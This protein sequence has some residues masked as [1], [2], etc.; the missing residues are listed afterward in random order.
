M[1]AFSGSIA[2]NSE[3]LRWGNRYVGGTLHTESRMLVLRKK[4]VED[5]IK[6]S[7]E[8][9]EEELT[10]FLEAI[11]VVIDMS[12]HMTYR[13]IPI[14][15]WFVEHSTEEDWI[16][17]FTNYDAFQIFDNHK[18]WNDNKKIR[19]MKQIYNA[20]SMNYKN[21]DFRS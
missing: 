9:F 1:S 7:I 6:C 19:Y 21:P 4:Y 2:I 15:Q 3:L 20:M 10:R 18:D 13:D 12:L 14:R 11:V 17:V 5:I 16:S 8:E